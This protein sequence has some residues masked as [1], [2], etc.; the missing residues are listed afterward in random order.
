MCN[1]VL[2]DERVSHPSWASE[3]SG[4]VAHKNV[5]EEAIQK[6]EE[7]HEYDF[8][9]EAMMKMNTIL[10]PI[11]TKIMQLSNVERFTFKLKLNWNGQLKSIQKLLKIWP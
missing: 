9:I 4:F 8:Y 7:R 2:N 6:S 11:H 1:S 5:Y 10:K 3:D